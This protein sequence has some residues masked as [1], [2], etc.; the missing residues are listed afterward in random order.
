MASAVAAVN[1]GSVVSGTAFTLKEIGVD[2]EASE[3]ASES[4]SREVY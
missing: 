4:D 1:T 3:D 2:D